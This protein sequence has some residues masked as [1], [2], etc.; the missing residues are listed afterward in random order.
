M[1]YRLSKEEQEVLE[2]LRNDIIKLSNRLW[3]F[4][5]SS[6]AVLRKV[7]ASYLLSFQDFKRS[8]LK[9]DGLVNVL[10]KRAQRFFLIEDNQKQEVKK[11]LIRVKTSVKRKL[12]R[13]LKLI[14]FPIY[15]VLIALSF[16]VKNKKKHKNNVINRYST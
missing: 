4:I 14:A 3:L 10:T 5:I 1:V 9:E 6:Y 11:K 15:L 2:I 16:L 12:K 13:T 7:S 8:N